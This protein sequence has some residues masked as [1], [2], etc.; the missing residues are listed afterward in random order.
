MRLIQLACSFA[1]ASVLGVGFISMKGCAEAG[2][3]LFREKVTQT[4]DGKTVTESENAKIRFP[5]NMDSLSRFKFSLGTVEIGSMS[6][7]KIEAK[8]WGLLLLGLGL[9]VLGVA[10]ALGGIPYVSAITGPM[11]VVGWS[12]AGAGAL[13]MVW[14]SIAGP[15]SIII[16]VGVAAVAAMG[17]ALAWG[18][19]LNARST[20]TR[21]EE[22]SAKLK[23][24]GKP[25]EA[26]AAERAGTL[27]L[28]KMLSDASALKK[29]LGVTTPPV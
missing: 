20:L 9:M 10:L 21:A 3:D 29:T 4:L 8:G 14:T 16:I 1:L 17:V 27:W 18:K 23:A 15:V 26:I 24:E 6:N 7:F 28:D 2:A 22:A 25:A 19:Y 5:K 13:C 11:P 12:T